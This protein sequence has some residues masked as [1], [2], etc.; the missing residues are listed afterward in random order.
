MPDRGN[1]ERPSA[2]HVE[3][4]S[5]KPVIAPAN[6]APEDGRAREPA[7]V[8]R[9]GLRGRVV[10]PAGNP[11]AGAHV[12]AVSRTQTDLDWECAWQADDWGPLDRRRLT[13]RADELGVFQLVE[14]TEGPQG[15]MV[16]ASHP[17]FVTGG[18][19]MP[20]SSGPV[21]EPVLVLER[22]PTLAVRVVGKNGEAV[23]GAVVV[24]YGTTPRETLLGDGRSLERARRLLVERAQTDERGMADVPRFAGEV[25][26]TASAEGRA[27]L[28]WRGVP[29]ASVDLVLGAS[30][31]VGGSVTLPDW[32]HLNYEGERRILIEAE[33]P[34]STLGLASVRGI[35]GG[36][37]GPVELPLLDGARYRLKL[38]GSPIIPTFHEF[39]APGPGEHLVLDV[40]AEVGHPLW[41]LVENEVG[42]AIPDAEAV[43]LWV[44]DGRERS[45][46]R[47]GD[48]LGQI[49][50]W[51]FPSGS[52]VRTFVTAPGYAGRWLEDVAFPE[53][54]PQTHLIIL[55]RSGSLSGKCMHDG[56]PVSDFQIVVW[57]PTRANFTQTH[58]VFRGRADGSFEF[59]DAPA[60]DIAV[61]AATADLP[62]CRPIHTTV[63]GKELV[64]ELLSPLSGRGQVV[65]LE[66]GEPVPQARVQALPVLPEGRLRP[67]G[68]EHSVDAE[69]R[70][71][72]EGFTSGQNGVLVSAPGY[73][74]SEARATAF[75]G[76]VDFGRIPLDRP[77]VVELRL[78]SESPVDFTQ[79]FGHGTKD[80][81][82]ST[83]GFDAGGVARI[84][85][86]NA[87]FHH[88]GLE[89]IPQATWAILAFDLKRGRTWKYSHKLNGRRRLT[90]DVTGSSEDSASIVGLGVSF[91]SPDGVRTQLGV[92]FE[93]GQT[94]SLEGIDADSACVAVLGPVKVKASTLAVL[95][96]E[97]LYG[98]LDLGEEPFHLRVVDHAGAPL[99]GVL[100]AVSDTLP[101]ALNLQTTTDS[102]GSCVFTGLPKRTILVSLEHEAHGRLLEQPIDASQ[103]EAMLV[104]TAGAGLRLQTLDGEAPIAGV[105]AQARVTSIGPRWSLLAHSDA[106]GHLQADGLGAGRILV[107]LDH[108][109]CWPVTVECRASNPAQPQRVQIR[110]LGALSLALRTP[111]GVA[112][113]GR[114][115]RLHSVEFDADVASWIQE[116]RVASKGGLVSDAK[117]EIRVQELPR[118][119]Y[120][121][122]L[123]TSVGETLEGLCEVLPGTQ[124]SVPIVVP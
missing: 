62:Y 51:S 90:V 57:E 65:D 8:K 113:P 111:D 15:W 67:W 6:D 30:F 71:S 2:A 115:L 12:Q 124:V 89:G 123:A 86:L 120:R 75:E 53:P 23:Q 117:G 96:G 49:A 36:A 58:R 29:G 116:G 104:L 38:E 94:L 54:A 121:Y 20:A 103:R 13:G 108:P 73:A 56:Q 31:T 69:G 45:L 21:A 83:F 80:T 19:V 74:E 27:S 109:E 48:T 22:G 82:L 64:I 4:V 37:W 118:G 5:A 52:Y 95:R 7:T 40:V 106:S 68:S 114:S 101:T 39:A 50:Q 24:Q 17:G 59:A 84:E 33:S 76:V 105:R 97:E 91:V 60:G 47:R 107:A 61:A 66:T 9:V 119:P 42:H 16:W 28:P 1:I 46:R 18:V 78:T 55:G 3:A 14:W 77:R 35:A 112:V 25:V 99:Q 63:P 100:V 81:V 34:T 72:F 43:S 92:P 26:L 88:V 44:Q 102:E 70:F 87:G 32:S 11:I 41:I 79:A 110:R 122:R 98:R 85:G 93:P 10:D